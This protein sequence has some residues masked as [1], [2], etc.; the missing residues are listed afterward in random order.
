VIVL[1]S[2]HLTVMGP[3]SLTVYSGVVQT[4]GGG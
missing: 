1:G 4:G 3:E 2:S